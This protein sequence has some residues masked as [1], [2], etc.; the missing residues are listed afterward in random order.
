VLPEEQLTEGGLKFN[1]T[2]ALQVWVSS[3][4]KKEGVLLIGAT[5]SAEPL[6]IPKCQWWYVEPSAG[7]SVPALLEEARARSIPGLMLT[8][9]GYSADDYAQS[10]RWPDLK[11][12]DLRCTKITD[13]GLAHL[14]EMKKLQLLNLFGTKITDAGLVY[15]KDMK[16]LQTLDLSCTKITDA[17]LAHLKELK[18]LR[19]LDLRSTRITQPKI[20][21]LRKVLLNTC[22]DY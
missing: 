10:G 1:S 13:A 22:V 19:E 3:R 21:E 6:A 7:V 9:A 12:L 2:L 11:M 16:G 17:G 4:E 20:E 15:V 5:P 14:K 18:G 8:L